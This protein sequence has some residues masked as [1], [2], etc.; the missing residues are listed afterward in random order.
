MTL[1]VRKALLRD[2]HTSLLTQSLLVLCIQQWLWIRLFRWPKRRILSFHN[3]MKVYYWSDQAQQLF[4]IQDRVDQLAHFRWNW[5]CLFERLVQKYL[6][7]SFSTYFEP[8]LLLGDF[9]KSVEV[10]WCWILGWV[11]TY[12][13][14]RKLFSGKIEIELSAI[15]RI[16]S[17][18]NLESASTGN[19]EK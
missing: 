9:W 17:F 1:T 2:V 3:H 16:C 18:S 14:F 15:F 5:L 8:Y 7:Q 4:W 10:K 11:W 13:R 19:V 12:V 6:K